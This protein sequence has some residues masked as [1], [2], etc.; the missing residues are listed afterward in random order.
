MHI[1]TVTDLVSYL[2]ELFEVNEALQ[3]CWVAGEISNHS[4]SPT[5]HHYFT[6]KEPS[7]QIK[8][9]L[10]R[11]N[12]S[13]QTVRPANGLQ[14]LLHGRLDLYE[15]SG[16]IQIM[17]DLVQLQGQGAA[18]LEFERLKERL[19]AEG[20]FA[21]ERKRPLPAY[22]RRIGLVTSPGAAA[23]QDILKVLGRR[24]PLAELI[25]SPT[26]VQGADAP[27]QICEA[28]ARLNALPGA[29]AVDVILLA[30]GGGAADELSAFNDERVV[31]AVF[32]SRVP[33]ITGVGHETDTTIVDYVADVRAPTP[34]AAAEM[35]APD[36]GGMLA[37]IED[38]RQELWDTM[39][40]YL[41]T[42]AAD[43]ADGQAILARHSPRAQI[44][45]QRQRL[46]QLAES[47]R[48]GLT[49]RLALQRAGLQ[50]Q[51][52]RLAA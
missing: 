30:R 13:W 29:R 7:A 18:A 14:V 50:T 17:V 9:V 51:Q 24:Y 8:C 31:R 21:P 46:D 23:F 39:S 38:L 3:D 36:I 25:L 2:K 45:Q 37:D 10:F 40:H 1:F 11:G 52:A 22:P 49:H 44:E 12:A 19:D 43:L 48:L 26:L 15:A 27:A 6:L 42:L 47:A 33:V 28:L 35:V 41:E 4:Q 20:L 5:G 16:S 34:S 32:A